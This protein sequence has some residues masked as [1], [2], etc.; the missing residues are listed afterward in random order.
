MT[1]V[2]FPKRY[3]L[4]CQLCLT[5]DHVRR[6]R[7]GGP[8]GVEDRRADLTSNALS[9]SAARSTGP[10]S[11]LSMLTR[12]RVLA[13]TR[14]TLRIRDRSTRTRRCQSHQ[15]C[16]QPL[17]SRRR[18][19]QVGSAR[20]TPHDWCSRSPAGTLRQSTQRSDEG[21]PVHKK[22]GPDRDH[23]V[24]RDGDGVG[25]GSGHETLPVGVG[26]ADPNLLHIG[27]CFARS[28]PD[29]DSGGAR[30]L[31]SDNGKIRPRRAGSL[32][33]GGGGLPRPA[34]SAILPTVGPTTST[35]ARR[36]SISRK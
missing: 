11:C 16:S 31:G 9:L 3:T 19:G 18:V 36:I 27:Q 26:R 23:R 8:H 4:G 30:R 32:D 25:W 14:S 20:T 22:P 34:D 15:R 10:L 13:T 29:L 2:I 17:L 5:R 35:T 33:L 21:G 28:D 7:A 1:P 6:S 12:S 24:N